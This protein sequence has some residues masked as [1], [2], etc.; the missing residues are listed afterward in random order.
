MK[1]LGA[2]SAMFAAAI[3]GGVAMWK[4]TNKRI[5]AVEASLAAKSDA[6]EVTRVRDAQGK[7]FDQMRE[8]KKEIMGAIGDLTGSFHEFAQ[9]VTE[10]LGKRPTRDELREKTRRA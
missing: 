2:V 4:G 9:K 5:A 1:A 7:I 8:D 3:A 6:R 10:E